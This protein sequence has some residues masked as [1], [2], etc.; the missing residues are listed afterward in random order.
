[1]KFVHMCGVM[2]ALAM[3]FASADASAQMAKRDTAAKLLPPG[4]YECKIG[5]YSFRECQIVAD[6]SGI[7]L[8]VP[9]GIGHFI[10]FEAEFMPSDDKGQLTMI[11]RLTSFNS[12]CPVCSDG[13][14][15]NDTCATKKQRDECASQPLVSRLK[16][17]GNAARGTLLY[18][19]VRP[20]YE[21]SGYVESFKL[22]NTADFQIRRAKK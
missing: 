12:L 21:G 5:S 4:N 7:K 17:S 20:A 6:G 19:I 2:C 22:G 13:S 15:E 14:P 8:I 11:G 9:K 16:V 18:Y 1:M 3:M 10:E